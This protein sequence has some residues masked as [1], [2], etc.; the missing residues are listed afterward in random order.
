MEKLELRMSNSKGKTK[1]I[2]KIIRISYVIFFLNNFPWLILYMGFS[3][4]TAL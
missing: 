3:Y 1:I 4:L 2:K